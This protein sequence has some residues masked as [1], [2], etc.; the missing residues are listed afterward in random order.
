M[1]ILRPFLA[2]RLGIAEHV[3]VPPSRVV[4]GGDAGSAI[5]DMFPAG[6]IVQLPYGNFDIILGPSLTVFSALYHVRRA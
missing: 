3:D 1:A 2:F 5:E 6:I 4:L